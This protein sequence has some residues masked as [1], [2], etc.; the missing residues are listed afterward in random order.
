MRI[1]NAYK[2]GKAVLAKHLFNKNTPINVMWRITNRC[3]SQCT[4][5]G[6]WNRKQKELT[7]SQ[8]LSLIDQ[9]AELDLLVAKLF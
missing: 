4:Y 7:T 3:D 1:T 2:I 8:I 6:I 5:C 9:I